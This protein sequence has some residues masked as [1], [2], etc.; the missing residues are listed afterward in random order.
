V[1]KNVIEKRNNLMFSKVDD[2]QKQNKENDITKK[3]KFWNIK[4]IIMY[5]V[6]IKH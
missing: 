6:K 1:C 2:S 5:I 4:R 3:D